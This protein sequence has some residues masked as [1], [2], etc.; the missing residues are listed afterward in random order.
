MSRYEVEILPDGRWRNMKPDYVV[1]NDHIKEGEHS[2]SSCK[3]SF[4]QAPSV[5]NMIKIKHKTDD[6][7]AGYMYCLSCIRKEYEEA[8][9]NKK[10]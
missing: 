1:F 7:C 9:K 2:C 10:V 6:I 8:L 4:C 5:F 3:C